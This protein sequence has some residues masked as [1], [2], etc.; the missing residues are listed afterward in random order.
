MSR[1]R[2]FRMFNAGAT[3]SSNFGSSSFSP[4]G[5]M[6]PP[7]SFNASRPYTPPSFMN[8]MG[9]GYN[10]MQQMETPDTVQRM[11]STVASTPK[12]TTTIALGT[13][14]SR[15]SI[16]GAT[17]RGVAKRAKSKKEP[18]CD[19]GM[20]ISQC[21]CDGHNHK[22]KAKAKKSTRTSSVKKA[23]PPD[24]NAI[25]GGAVQNF[26]NRLN[27]NQRR[28]TPPPLYPQTFGATVNIG[29]DGGLSGYTSF[30]RP[31]K[32]SVGSTMRKGRGFAKARRIRGFASGIQQ[33][34]GG[35]KGFS[36]N[37]PITST[38]V[39]DVMMGLASRYHGS[40]EMY[41]ALGNPKQMLRIA[42]GI[43]GKKLKNSAK[44]FGLNAVDN[45]RAKIANPI[46]DKIGDLATRRYGAGSREAAMVNQF[47]ANPKDKSWRA[48]PRVMISRIADI[49]NARI[50]RKMDNIRYN[51]YNNPSFRNVANRIDD[52]VN[53]IDDVTMPYVLPLYIA[54]QKR[55]KSM[56]GRIKNLERT[57]PRLAQA[58]KIA[59]GVAK[60]RYVLGASGAGLALHN[61]GGSDRNE[62]TSTGAGMKKSITRMGRHVVGGYRGKSISKA[63]KSSQTNLSN[64][65]M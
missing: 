10:R 61:M 22:T 57:N 11:N 39:D 35:R 8:R 15:R 58:S 64:K 49:E 34:V 52:V 63:M 36:R 2:K 1:I 44:M 54:N 18:L 7:P 20:P 59:L 50:G 46:A 32:G 28:Y 55:Q 38:K 30:Y 16:S 14:D 65:Y 42:A 9:T 23:A 51:V 43:E 33:L 48:N 3:P 41:D 12:P 31:Q 40:K 37:F 24:Y 62:P 27:T 47:R 13:G 45:L 29:N 19:C 6:T 56:Y 53:R 21:Q 25:F 4:V 5:R 60:P 26:A 17:F